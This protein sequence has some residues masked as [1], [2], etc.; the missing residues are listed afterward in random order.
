M[1]LITRLPFTSYS[2]ARTLDTILYMHLK[3]KFDLN[4]SIDPHHHRNKETQI[5][6]FYCD[7]FHS[8]LNFIHKHDSIRPTTYNI[9]LSNIRLNP[10]CPNFFKHHNSKLCACLISYSISVFSNLRAIQV[11]CSL[12][13]FRE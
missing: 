12:D 9:F 6:L 10:L 3:I 4:Y 13:Y 1:Q 5:V 8:N 7:L 11:I 2:L